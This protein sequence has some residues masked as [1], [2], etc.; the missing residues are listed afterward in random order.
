M[1]KRAGIV[2]V[3]IIIVLILAFTLYK[4][5]GPSQKASVIDSQQTTP[6]QSNQEVRIIT[7]LHQYKDG[8]HIIAGQTEVPTPCHVLSE[9]VSVTDT[10]PA[11]V[12]VAFTSAA[13][14]DNCA[15][16]ETVARFKTDFVAP[17]N[18]VFSATWNGA[19]AQLNLVPAGADDNLE[20]FDVFIKG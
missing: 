12:T 11:Q 14:A 2:I 16:V 3:A 17:E 20:D 1:N 9:T 7:A 10:T 15:Q 18:S 13:S 8:K 6:V 19:P 4:Q 5:F